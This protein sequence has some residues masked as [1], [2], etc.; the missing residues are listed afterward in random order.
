MN[1]PQHRFP[2]E[3]THTS[4]WRQVT[5]KLCYLDSFDWSTFCRMGYFQTHKLT[6]VCPP[7]H[8]DHRNKWLDH[9]LQMQTWARHLQVFWFPMVEQPFSYGFPW[10]NHHF[11]RVSHA[12]TQERMLVG[13][14]NGHLYV[15]DLATAKLLTVQNCGK[16]S[17]LLQFKWCLLS[18]EP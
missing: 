8:V 3:D 9:M 14:S 6:L 5:I 10:L 17:L 18:L 1:R 4:E 7:L 15:M 2:S 12:Q 13:S 11:P 16:G